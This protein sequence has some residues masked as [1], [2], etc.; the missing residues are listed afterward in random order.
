MVDGLGTYE[1]VAA[2][3]G[4]KLSLV[5]CWMHVRRKYVE[6][7]QAVP[8]AN[9]ALEMI[10]GLYAVERE[11][12]EGPEN[13]ERLLALRQQKSR[14][15]KPGWVRPALCE[16][17]L[18]LGHV[19]AGLVPTEPDVHG[20]VTLME[21]QASRLRA[22]VG[23]LDEPVLLLEQNRGLWDRVLIHRGLAALERAEKPGG[24]RGPYTLQA[25][26]AACHARALTPQET[27]WARI[28][29]LYEELVRSR[30]THASA[31]C[32]WSTPPRAP[33]PRPGAGEVSTRL[34]AR[35]APRSRPGAWLQ[36]RLPARPKFRRL[37][38]KG[39]L[40]PHRGDSPSSGIKGLPSYRVCSPVHAGPTPLVDVYK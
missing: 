7:A 32:C 6:C 40:C 34:E 22:R 17:A 16:D 31:T 33:A 38:L 1:S 19:L 23:P 13:L 20:L 9:E 25:A 14:P 27:D 11:Y 12:K 18:R 29:A 5:N 3:P 4:G 21:I 15:I 36:K 39:Y 28:A 30:A 24:Q 26:I 10:A 37:N 2:G 35:N 8:Q